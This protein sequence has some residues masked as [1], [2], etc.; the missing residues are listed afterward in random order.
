MLVMRDQPSKILAGEAAGGTIR[1]NG[2][3]MHPL[4]HF[5]ESAISHSSDFR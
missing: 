1:H 2:P 5:S 4:R 3:E